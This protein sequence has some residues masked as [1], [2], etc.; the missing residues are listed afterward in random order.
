MTTNRSTKQRIR[1]FAE[2]S[3]LD[4]SYMQAKQMVDGGTTGS[5]IANPF[6]LNDDYEDI[7]YER[8]DFIATALDDVS[9][10]ELRDFYDQTARAAS[11][12]ASKR[13]D[14]PHERNAFAIASFISAVENEN[15]HATSGGVI[16]AAFQMYVYAMTGTWID[17]DTTKLHNGKVSY[18]KPQFTND[19]DAELFERVVADFKTFNISQIIYILIWT[20]R[21][22]VEDSHGNYVGLGEV[23]MEYELR[24]DGGI[25]I[26]AGGAGA[27]F[28][29]DTK[30]LAESAGLSA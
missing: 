6:M 21:A 8:M 22:P 11:T 3:P 20:C 29:I 26:H 4:L 13:H 18:D 28:V 10:V 23:G 9:D 30:K 16:I 2:N 27:N 17:C 7:F 15:P 25:A 5:Y 19:D 12:V 24:A 1:E 14:E